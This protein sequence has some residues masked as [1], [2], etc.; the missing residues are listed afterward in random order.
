MTSATELPGWC[1]TGP[2]QAIAEFVWTVVDMAAGW[3]TVH[4]PTCSPAKR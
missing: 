2:R 3:V 4:R 1:G